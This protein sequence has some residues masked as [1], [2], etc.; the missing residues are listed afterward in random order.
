MKKLVGKES[1]ENFGKFDIGD[2]VGI[3]AK[4]S[5]NENGRTHP[6]CG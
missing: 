4:V 6:V 1:Y 2:I 5:K 3:H